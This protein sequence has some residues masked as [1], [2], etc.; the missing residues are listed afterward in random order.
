MYSVW[1]P[2]YFTRV[3]NSL[4]WLCQSFVPASLCVPCIHSP[5]C[6]AGFPLLVELTLFQA[7]GLYVCEFLPSLCP[8]A[9]LPSIS[10]SFPPF[11]C[12]QH[13]QSSFLLRATTFLLFSKVTSLCS[14]VWP[15]TRSDPPAPASWVLGLPVRVTTPSFILYFLME[16]NNALVKHFL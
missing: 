3:L 5:S 8:L 4:A 11:C 13:L 16:A 7:L 10:V 1:K 2:L 14:P 6:I 9:L 12:S 15:Q